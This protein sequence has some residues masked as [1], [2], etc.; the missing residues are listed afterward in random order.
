MP[1]SN[2]PYASGMFPDVVKQ[3]VAIICYI[4]GYHSDQWLDE[5]IIGFMSIFIIGQQTIILTY[6]HFI[7]EAM[8]EQLV[9]FPTEGSF[10]YAFVLVY[11]FLYYQSYSFSCSL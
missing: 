5:A 8:H 7:A 11:F 2:P 9:K 6:I 4:L 10:K 3:L 1:K